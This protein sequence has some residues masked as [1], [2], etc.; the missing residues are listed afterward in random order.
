MAMLLDAMQWQVQEY[1]EEHPDTMKYF[2]HISTWLNGECW[3]KERPAK[4]DD[5]PCG[6]AND[7][8]HKFS[9]VK[10]R[11]VYKCA[12]CRGINLKQG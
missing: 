10:G 2:P 1:K 5:C 6:K 11:K 4:I 12:S 8:T 9:M 7:G 3:D